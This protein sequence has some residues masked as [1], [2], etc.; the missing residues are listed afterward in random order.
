MKTK[1]PK[2]PNLAYVS[3]LLWPVTTALTFW[4][5]TK[6]N[7]S[8]CIQ[9]KSPISHYDVPASHHQ[10]ADNVNVCLA[11]IVVDL[12]AAPD[13][14]PR[15]K[16]RILF[17]S[18]TSAKFVT[19]QFFLT[20]SQQKVWTLV[21]PSES[22][23]QMTPKWRCLSM[24]HRTAKSYCCGIRFQDTLSK[25][26]DKVKIKKLADKHLETWS[27]A[28]RGEAE[29]FVDHHEWIGVFVFVAWQPFRWWYHIWPLQVTQV[30][31]CSKRHGRG[32]TTDSFDWKRK[33][34]KVLKW[35]GQGRDWNAVQGPEVSCWKCS[36][37]RFSVFCKAWI[38]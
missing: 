29:I 25:I 12:A 24:N 10:K 1:W 20:I 33:R 17:Q 13:V 4:I 8:F 18:D 14:R 2:L 5:T 9:W 22:S 23:G 19:W 26:D 11:N 15:Q 27:V 36:S 37:N 7:H 3:S 35:S 28:E 38:N 34:I 16:P 32:L 30:S 31:Y 21:L 6:L